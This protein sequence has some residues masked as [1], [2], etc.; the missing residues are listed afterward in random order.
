MVAAMIAR[1]FA[2]VALAMAALALPA[3][4]QQQ[5]QTRRAAA[6]AELYTS[7]GCIQC[8]RANR[9]LGVF[10]REDDV[11]ALTFP[12]G[13]WDYLG[14]HD[15]FARPE[16]AERQRAYSRTM[17]VR[18][19]FTPQ[20]VVNGVRQLSASDWDEA[21]A[22][23]DEQRQAGLGG[24]PEITLTQIRSGRI[25]ATLSSGAPRADADVWMVAY[26]PGPI[27]VA[28][29]A[30][31]NR[32]RYISHYNLVRWIERVGVWNGQSAWFEHTRCLP[33]CAVIVQEPNGGRVLA[34][35]YTTRVTQRRQ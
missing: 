8:P 5:P 7:Q 9:L 32:N 34:A 19:R 18:G 22:V 35:T 6:V 30:G 27:T 33:L 12:V 29:T 17:H 14:W 13:I 26:E 28:I 2:A 20:L 25:R 15:T 31:I 11:L 23:L 4:A 1:L 16:F 10:S 21:R 3:N 24:A